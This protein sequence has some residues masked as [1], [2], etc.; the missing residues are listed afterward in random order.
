MM[1]GPAYPLG[2]VGV[3][4][5]AEVGAS[6][7]V[8]RRIDL[9]R[10]V[11]ERVVTRDIS[12]L[13]SGSTSPAGSKLLQGG[14]PT[15]AILPF[16]SSHPSRFSKGGMADPQLAPSW[17]LS[18]TT[19][20]S[21]VPPRGP[22]PIPTRSFFVLVYNHDHPHPWVD[23]AFP[24]GD[25][26]RQRRASSRGTGFCVASLH[27]LIRVTLGLWSERSVREYLGTLRG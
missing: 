9:R 18:S 20:P 17:G 6:I 14:W 8:D 19:P 22:R 27:K 16:R 13:I 5:V 4:T 10:L 11:K 15:L 1:N 21:S 7:Q 25:S 26:Q 23:T 12:R 3:P 2:P 24:A